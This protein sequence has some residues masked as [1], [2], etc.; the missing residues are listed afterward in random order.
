[1]K[2]LRGHQGCIHRVVSEHRGGQDGRYDDPNKKRR[3]NRSSN[4]VV[5]NRFPNRMVQQKNQEGVEDAL[6]E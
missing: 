3:K 5:R 6:V 4:D 2:K 1:M